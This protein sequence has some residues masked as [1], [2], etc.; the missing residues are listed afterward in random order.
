M[1]QTFVQE[2]RRFEVPGEILSEWVIPARGYSGITMR[3]DDV[4]RLIDLEGQQVPD[5]VCFNANDLTERLNL[6]N[7]MHLNGHLHFKQGD[8]LYSVDCNPMMTI[9]GYS[10][11]NSFSFGP[12][13]SEELN[14]IRFGA[15]NSANCRHN[16]EQAL[17]PW[18]ISRRDVP[19]AFV[20][21]MNVVIRDDGRV[22][23]EAPTTEPGDYYDLRAELDLVVGLSNCP[24]EFNAVNGFNPTALG[25]IVYR[26]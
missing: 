11:E 13:C 12:M 17:A 4:L 23:S 7:S 25:V 10:N 1:M 18:G 24:Q 5:V 2:M 15:A 16:M 6:Q 19:N 14:R 9:V 8:V 3:R 21:F 20:P 22:E 26:A